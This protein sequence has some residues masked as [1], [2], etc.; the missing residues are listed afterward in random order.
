MKRK[1]RLSS[2][3]WIFSLVFDRTTRKEEKEKEK[4]FSRLDDQQSLLRRNL[5][6]K[7]VMSLEETNLELRR[8]IWLDKFCDATQENRE[9]QD[10]LR[11]IINCLV[12]FDNYQSFEYFLKHQIKDQEEK[13]LLI[14]SGQL[15]QEIIEN[16]HQHKQII[17]ILVFCGNK[18]KNELW[19]KNY[20]KVYSFLELLH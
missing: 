6:K 17:S 5:L 20:P 14:V 19:A 4:D 18:Q 11:S 9:I 16:I 13:I 10:K 8:L 12:T 15:G 1:K 7:V 2:F 3:L